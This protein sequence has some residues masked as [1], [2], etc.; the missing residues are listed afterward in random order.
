MMP[1]IIGFFYADF[2]APNRLSKGSIRT[3]PQI[4]MMA[5]IP[6]GVMVWLRMNTARHAAMTGFR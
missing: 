5:R 6:Q 1:V 3:D 2:P 4:T